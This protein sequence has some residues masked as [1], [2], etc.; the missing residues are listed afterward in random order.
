MFAYI[1]VLLLTCLLAEITQRISEK[2]NK[3]IIILLSL[4]VILVP[5]AFAGLRDTK[6][7][8]DVELYVTPNFY[9]ATQSASLGEYFETSKEEPLYTIMNFV[10]SRFTNDVNWLL[11]IIQLI[12]T[13][14]VYVTIY[15]QRKRMPMWFGMMVYMILFYTRFLNLIRQGIAVC[16]VVFAFNFIEDK[17]PIKYFASIIIAML[18]HRTAIVALPLYFINILLNKEDKKSKKIMLGIYILVIASIFFY[19]IILNVLL[20]INILPNKF[21][22]YLT[23][24]KKESFDPE[25]FYTLFKLIWVIWTILLYKNIKKNDTSVKF[26]V[27]LLL[28]DIIFLQY[29]TRILNAER[30]SY[31]FGTIGEILLIP[32][33]PIA[34]NSAFI[35]QLLEK[36][37]KKFK[38]NII[39]KMP[40]KL[41]NII[42]NAE[43]IKRIT[44]IV[45]VLLLILYF[46]WYYI[47]YSAG[48]IY[49]Y[50]SSILGI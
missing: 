20:N 33:I 17:K 34:N 3:K 23:K 40:K 7:G 5:S 18:F 28:F 9:Y 41:T 16:I 46:Y 2:N 8:T 6:I 14:L 10:V 25:I 35:K 49:P 1:L 48:E 22:L 26:K 19:D 27:S 21:E 50:K 39:N 44:T 36:I 42:N 29:S 30:I 38:I 12:M 15:K 32:Q 47:R 13:S 43:I 11:F 4:L 45:I 24:Y 37:E 31:Y